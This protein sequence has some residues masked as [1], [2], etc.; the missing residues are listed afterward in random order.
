MS[1]ADLANLVNEA[2]LLA[3]RR[4][5]EKVYMDDLEDA[6]D[7]VMLGAER[8]SLVLS[9]KERELT[10]YHEAGHAVV[11]LRTPGLDPVHKITIVPRGRALGITAS[12]PEEDRHSYSK[13]YLLSNLAMLYGG[14]AAEELIFGVEKITTGA[15]NDIERA[16]AMARRMVTQFGMSDVIGPMAVGDSEQEVFLGR[17]LVQ[18][19]EI[20]ERTSE[21]VDEEIKRILDEAYVRA[22]QTLQENRVLLEKISEALL[23]R[24]T[25]DREDVDLLAAGRPLPEFKPR[26]PLGDGENGNKGSG[27]L[28]GA[29]TG[30]PDTAS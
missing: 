26:P 9:E 17:E 12:L 19:R 21:N 13:D 15:G 18:R 14:R 28:V 24:E 23:E 6:K 4:G 27:T 2:A 1:G 30:S 29:G 16:T 20:S 5:R 8:K 22:R 11:A 7:K 3:A 10:A 25:L